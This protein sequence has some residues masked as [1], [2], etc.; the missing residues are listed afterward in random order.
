MFEKCYRQH[1]AER[2]LSD[3]YV[4]DDAERVIITHLRE[5]FGNMYTVKIDAM[6]N[7]IRMSS[8]MDRSLL[9]FLAQDA[10]RWVLADQFQFH[11]NVLTAGCWPSVPLSKTDIVPKELLRFCDNFQSFY[12]NQFP[13]RRLRWQTSM[14]SARVLFSPVSHLCSF[15]SRYPWITLSVGKCNDVGTPNAR[16]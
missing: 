3:L 16:A 7:D 4:I 10:N 9:H 2:L 12:S 15:T 8:S 13:G 1:L 11:A 6:V 5:E 14:G